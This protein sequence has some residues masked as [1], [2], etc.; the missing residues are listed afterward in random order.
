MACCHR[1]GAAVSRIDQGGWR[2]SR[3]CV[4]FRTHQE[5]CSTPENYGPTGT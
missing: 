5:L 2:R 4:L 3:N 1:I